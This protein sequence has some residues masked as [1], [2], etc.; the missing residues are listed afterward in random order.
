M[1]ILPQSPT[2]P[3]A[4]ARTFTPD[5]RQ[6]LAIDALAGHQ[7]IAEIARQNDVSRKFVYQQEQ[8]AQQALTEVFVPQPPPDEKIL[9]TIP[10]TKS[11]IRRTSMALFLDCHSSL[12]GAKDFFHDVF[13]Y[14]I[15]V[16]TLFNTAHADAP[17]ARLINNQQDLS[18]VRIAVPDEIFQASKPVLVGVDAD[19]TYCFLLSQE[20]RRDAVTW[21]VRLMELQ[22][23]G[24]RPEATISDAG[25]GIR[26]GQQLAQLDVPCRNDVFHALREFGEVNRFLENRAYGMIKAADKLERE[27]LALRKHLGKLEEALQRTTRLAERADTTKRRQSLKK[28]QG[29]VD[30]QR[31]RVDQ[32]LLKTQAA[33]QAQAQVIDLAD[34]VALLG[35]WLREDILSVAGT[36]HGNRLHLYDM[37]VAELRRRQGACR[38]RL[39]PLCRYLENQRDALLAFAAVLDSDLAALAEE[40]PVSLSLLREMVQVQTMSVDDPKRWQQDAKLRQQLRALYYPVSEAVAEVRDRTVRASSVVE[41]L[42]SKLRGYF[43]LRRTLG[44]DSLDLLRFYLNHRRF[45]RSEHPERVGKSPTELLTGQEHADW[46][47]LLGYPRFSRN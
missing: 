25:S 11:F 36:D 45:Q 21:A 42:N 32:W 23:K 10:V 46:L 16:G 6:Q 1:S 26:A 38:H 39:E 27:C 15:S 43:F 12:R 2:H 19:T 28:L 5:L 30:R 31:Q 22:D 44:A 40:F 3:I 37:V 13:D 8:K 35:R 33:R 7:P 4:T 34:D 9:F 41:N 17:K 24:F 14:S 29:K 18:D 47:D 20:E